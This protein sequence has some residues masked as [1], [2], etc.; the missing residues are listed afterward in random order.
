MNR[1]L[2]GKEHSLNSPIGEDGDEWQDW[3]I[4]KEMDQELK[5]FKARR[6][7]TKK[8]AFRRFCKNIK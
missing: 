3:L 2:S 8:R 6:N 4:D 7:E 5:F 1:R